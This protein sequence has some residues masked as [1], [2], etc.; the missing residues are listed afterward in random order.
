MTIYA[1]AHSINPNTRASITCNTEFMYSTN[2]GI[3][4]STGIEHT[5][6]DDITVHNHSINDHDPITESCWQ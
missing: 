4:H 2:T 5:A 1:P 6:H 3:R